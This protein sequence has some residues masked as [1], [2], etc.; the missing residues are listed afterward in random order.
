MADGVPA[1]LPAQQHA[2]TAVLA[3]RAEADGRYAEAAD[4]YA[5]AA[6]RWER[7]TNV[8][9]QAHALLGQGRSLAASGDSAADQPLRHARHLF[10]QMGARPFVA[11]CDTL[12]AQASKLSS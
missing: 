5:E 12:I 3:I 6:T 10:S 7:F 4:L 9:E 2:L 1:T 11:E 8:L